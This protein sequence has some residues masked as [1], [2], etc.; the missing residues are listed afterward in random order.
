[1]VNNVKREINYAAN[2]VAT[3]IDILHDIDDTKVFRKKFVE[4]TET[5][6]LL[7]SA[8][9]DKDNLVKKWSVYVQF[10]KVEEALEKN[11]VE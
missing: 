4:L 9:I 2:S 7:K 6:I 1:M 11:P 8:H 3:L 5:E 10:N